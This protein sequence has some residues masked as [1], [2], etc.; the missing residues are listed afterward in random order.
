MPDPMTEPLDKLEPARVVLDGETTYLVAMDR[1]MFVAIEAPW[2]WIE[3]HPTDPAVNEVA[4]AVPATRTKHP[5]PMA[6]CVR[7]MMAKGPVSAIHTTIGRLTDWAGTPEWSYP[8]AYCKATGKEIGDCERCKGKGTLTCHCID[9]GDEHERECPVCDGN[10]AGT[11]HDGD[12]CHTCLGTGCVTEV[13][14][15]GIVRGLVAGIVV[16]KRRLARMLAVI[17][18]QPA[19]VWSNGSSL[20]IRWHGSP[21]GHAVLMAVHED[22]VEALLDG[23][24][25]T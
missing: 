10:G 23:A 25:V 5:E 20:N 2:A 21:R 18:K 19:E 14:A 4:R 8:C 17:D 6:A 16:D 22:N 13:P 11:T 9:C 15:D 7:Q 24:F 12:T 3:M 1:H